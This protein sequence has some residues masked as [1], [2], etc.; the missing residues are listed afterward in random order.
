MIN[1]FPIN[2]HNTEYPYGNFPSQYIKKQQ[3]DTKNNQ[4][5]NYYTETKFNNATQNNTNNH[6]QQDT[7]NHLNFDI[8]SLLPIITALT[9]KDKPNNKSLITTLLPLLAGN[10]AKDIGALLK[11]FENKTTNKINDNNFK[12]TI[13]PASIYN[14]IDTY[15]RI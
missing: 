7:H 15:E 10:K 2:S 12:E 8:N 11:F 13:L 6:S 4:T 14:P 3:N 9:N 1:N 5:L